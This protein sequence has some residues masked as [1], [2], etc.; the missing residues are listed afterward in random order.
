[1]PKSDTVAKKTKTFLVENIL[2]LE[3]VF[4]ERTLSLL[5]G[6]FDKVKF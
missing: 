1:M 3:K 6:D 4:L 2:K 5:L